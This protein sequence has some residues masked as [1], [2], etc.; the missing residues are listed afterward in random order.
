MA[1]DIM[2]KA[3]LQSEAKTET[4]EKP[5][6]RIARQHNYLTYSQVTKGMTPDKLLIHLES[7]VGVVKE[8]LISQERHKDGGYHLHAYIKHKRF[9]SEN[10]NVFDW[11]RY[12][13]AYHPNIKAVKGDKYRL[14]RYIKKDGE[15]I[16][17]FD[18][19]PE[20]QRL[21]EDSVNDLEFYQNLLFAVGG[22]I[23]GYVGSKALFKLWDIKNGL[24]SDIPELPVEH[25]MDINEYMRRKGIDKDFDSD[26]LV[27]GKLD[28]LSKALKRTKQKSI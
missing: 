8:Y 21:I 18:S 7:I 11:T 28:L 22:R 5:V 4:A 15:F 2:P 27:E 10:A 19:R 16:S 1:L 12:R 20:W 25:K 26:H 9:E 6:F 24:P 13:K 3:K 17:N 23:S 14:F